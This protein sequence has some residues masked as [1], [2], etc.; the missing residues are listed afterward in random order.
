MKSGTSTPAR[1]VRAAVL[2]ILLAFWWLPPARAEEVP[3]SEQFRAFAALPGAVVT[4]RTEGGEQVR[5]VQVGGVV[6]QE[7]QRGSRVQTVGIDRTGYGSVLCAWRIYLIMRSTIDLCHSGEHR[8][9]REDADAALH[10]ITDFVVTNDP[11]NAS[12]QQWEE[13]ARRIEDDVR[14]QLVGSPTGAANRC[15]MHADF[16]RAHPRPHASS[17]G[18]NLRTFSPFRGHR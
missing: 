5:E 17:V 3:A 6:L 16:M 12:R 18:G 2:A 4:Q 14:A 8:E 10:S 15:L 9:L 13:R 1:R 7:T 11:L